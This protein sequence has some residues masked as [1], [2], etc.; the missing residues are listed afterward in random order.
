MGKSACQA[1]RG[2]GCWHIPLAMPIRHPSDPLGDD[3]EEV[4][5][6]VEEEDYLRI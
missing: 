3:E 4:E 1:G 2:V 6:R 5:S